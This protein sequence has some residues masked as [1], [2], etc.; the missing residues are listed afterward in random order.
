MKTVRSHTNP[1]RASRYAWAWEQIHHLR[2]STHLD[3]GCFDGPRLNSL[4]PLGVDRRVGFDVNSESIDV[5]RRSHP[6]VE[7]QQISD[8]CALPAQ[9]ASFDSVTLL[10]VYEHLDLPRQRGVMREIWRVLRPGGML[11]LTV[12]RKHVLSVLDT[13]NFKFRV[14]SLH[15]WFVSWRHSEEYYTQRYQSSPHGLVGDIMASKRWHEHFSDRE[16]VVMLQSRG[17]SVL[18]IDGSG[19]FR[20]PLLLVPLVIPPR[21][22]PALATVISKD[23]NR[24]HRANLFIR[25]AKPR[26]TG[27]GAS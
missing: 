6:Q 9:D 13:G 11:L 19:F 22:R 26:T 20:R 16:Q 2:P 4:G 25:A 1:F 7:L 8:I 10:D 3:I 24:F 18:S 12:P 5:G 27:V 21:F 14:P 17:F 23:E 15:R